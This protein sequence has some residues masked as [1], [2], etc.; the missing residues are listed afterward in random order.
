MCVLAYVDKEG[1]QT[2]MGVAPGFLDFSKKDEGGF[3]F[4]PIFVPTNGNPERLSLGQMRDEKRRSLSG[5]G[6]AVTEFLK[7]THF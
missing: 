4:C 7:V 6:R 1:E 5:R 2:F 3:G